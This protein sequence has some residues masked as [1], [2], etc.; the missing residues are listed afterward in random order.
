MKRLRKIVILAMVIIF[1][2]PIVACS[3]K[4]SEDKTLTIGAGR[5]FVEGSGKVNYLHKTTNV[6]E[7]LIAL[8]EDMN[9]IPELAEKMEVSNDGL[10]WIITLKEDVKFH[11]NTELN[12]EIAKANLERTYH[13]SPKEKKVVEEYKNSDM[14]EIEEITVVNDYKLEVKH[15]SPV[16]DFDSRLAYTNGQMF[17]L[18]SFNED[19]QINTPIGSGPFK[20]DNYDEANLVLTLTRFDGYRKGEPKL[21]KVIFK[22]IPDADTRLAALKSGEID[23]ISDVGAIIPTQAKSIKEDENLE[24]KEKQ[25]STNHYL[26]VNMNEGKIFSNNNLRTALSLAIDRETIVKELLEG[27]GLPAKSTITTLSKT[28]QKDV[29]YE[30][31]IEK[32]KQLAKEALG[33]T[34][35]SAVIVLN[36]SL[37]GRWPYQDVAVFMKAKLEEIGIDASIEIVDSATW[38]DRMK[39]GDYDITISPY[40]I[41]TGEPNFFF[42]P[43]MA[44]YGSNNKG[45]SYGYKNQKVDD[46]IKSASCEMDINKRK[47]YYNELQTIAKEEGPVIPIWHDITL[48]AINKKVQKFELDLTFW[49][50]LYKVDIK[51]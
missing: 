13:F 27:Y 35:G 45:R 16:P 32:S 39:K 31:D 19:G 41:T 48:Y 51:E 21:S 49:P 30:Y 22:S 18:A 28:W 36:S 25:V 33:D 50:D 9:P 24:L 6:W 5:D 10:T 34:R 4:E 43:H 3:K 1:S 42:E 46:L 8:D 26:N 37:I 47:D 17:S 14:G 38:S 12:A 15:K 23:A 2:L 20:Y 44:S 40:T 11:D 29:G 7:S